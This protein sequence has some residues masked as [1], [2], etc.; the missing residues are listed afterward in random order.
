[1][2]LITQPIVLFA[3]LVRYDLRG[4]I[5]Y[6]IRMCMFNKKKSQNTML[7]CHIFFFFSSGINSN[8]LFVSNQLFTLGLKPM[9]HYSNYVPSV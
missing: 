6:G 2:P 1:M 7:L 5:Q 9:D 4:I 3:Q 8:K